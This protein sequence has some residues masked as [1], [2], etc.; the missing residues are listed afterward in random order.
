MADRRPLLFT[1]PT[2]ELDEK[3]QALSM[4][5]AVAWHQAQAYPEK[6]DEVLKELRAHVRQ[7]SMV[8]RLFLRDIGEAA[9]RKGN[10][11]E[12][13]M[14]AAEKRCRAAL[15][16]AHTTAVLD[17][18]ADPWGYF[19][20]VLWSYDKAV[21]V[22]LSTNLLSRLGSHMGE[23]AKRVVVTRVTVTRCKSERQM[24]DTEARL[25]TQWQPPMNTVGCVGRSV[26][27]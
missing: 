15:A 26:A 6:A 4:N 24:R 16:E 10:A 3:L 14:E 12:R 27:E 18:L 13:A 25:I 7:V 21:Y 11:M 1:R 17:A 2:A 22:G 23:R 20:Y 5:V 8:T 9:D 19:V